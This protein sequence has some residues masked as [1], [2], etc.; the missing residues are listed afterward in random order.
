M[1]GTPA[2]PSESHPRLNPAGANQ[3]CEDFSELEKV[4]NAAIEGGA[5]KILSLIVSLICTQGKYEQA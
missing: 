1:T 5:H 4:P 3:S 2:A